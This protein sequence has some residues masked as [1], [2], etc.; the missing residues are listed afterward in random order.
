MIDAFPTSDLFCKI[1]RLSLAIV[2]FH[3]SELLCD[4]LY[5][6]LEIEMFIYVFL[7]KEPE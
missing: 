1:L 5:L 4:T 2:T 6:S 3:S 7:G